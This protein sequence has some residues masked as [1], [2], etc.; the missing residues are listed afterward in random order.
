MC[1]PSWKR[2][3]TLAMLAC[4]LSG[5]AA[6]KTGVV[7]SALTR[8]AFP[9]M[10]LSAN[11][12]LSL[13]GY[14]ALPVSFATDS[15]VT[16]ASG[17]MYYAL[18]AE[19]SAGLVMRGAHVLIAQISNDSRWMFQP[20]SGVARG[21]LAAGTTV[22]NGAVW[23]VRTLRIMNEEDWFSALWQAN[24]RETPPVWIARRFT[25]TPGGSMRV[26]A[27]YREPWPDCLDIGVTDLTFARAECLGGFMARS[28][29]AF[30]LELHTT[31]TGTEPLLPALTMPGFAPDMTRIAGRVTENISFMR[32][33]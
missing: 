5:C 22:L 30:T 4:L 10:T 14:G 11:A 27:E 3:L 31:A 6:A 13:R 21:V 1:C 2:L 7:G 8:N 33:R 23:T 19:D 17:E 18:Y 26:A 15:L 28:D 9:R 25:A 24:G 16:E 32:W 20:D 12:P 29:Q